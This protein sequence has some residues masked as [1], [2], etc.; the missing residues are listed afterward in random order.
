MH[1]YFSFRDALCGE[2]NDTRQARLQRDAQLSAELQALYAPIHHH[3]KELSRLNNQHMVVARRQV[4]DDL[5]KKCLRALQKADELLR[6]EAK[7][8]EQELL[9]AAQAQQEEERRQ[10]DM[11]AI[12]AEDYKNG[13]AADK[14]LSLGKKPRKPRHIDTID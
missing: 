5:N 13:G 10:M 6:R 12:K 11:D 4:M 7:V 14:L 8:E 9:N 1:D 3:L 2:D